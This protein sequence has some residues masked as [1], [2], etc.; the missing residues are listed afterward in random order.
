MKYMILIY[1]NEELWGSF[2]E[3]SFKQAVA[4]TEAQHAALT[5][6]GE[7][8]GAWGV[9]DQAVAKTVTVA[10]GERIVTD[11][12]YIETKEYLA[13]FEIVDVES[14]ERAIEIAAEV[15]F[16]RIGRVEIR[17]LLHESDSNT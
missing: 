14:E 5:A 7:F 2:D 9:G 15:P 10:D 17:P 4:D 16:A 8:V 12:P 1:G 6:S 3:A 11:G 13:S